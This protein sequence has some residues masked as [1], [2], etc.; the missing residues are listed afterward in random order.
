MFNYSVEL[1]VI[2][3]KACNEAFK[4]LSDCPEPKYTTTCV[5]KLIFKYY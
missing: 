1:L 5:F 3:E 2:I 4:N